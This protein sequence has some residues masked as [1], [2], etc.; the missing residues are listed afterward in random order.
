MTRPVL[1]VPGYQGSGPTHWQSL[2]ESALPEAR[3]VVMPDWEH[4]EPEG[5]IAALDAAVAACTEP[6]L[7][8]GHSLGCIAIVH[9]ALGHPR[10]IHGALLVAPA[11]VERPGGLEA[12]RP[13]GPIPQDRLPF[14][15]ILAASANDGFMTH[16]RAV[17]LAEAWGAR[18]VDLGAVGHLNVASGHGL[19][20]QGEALLAELR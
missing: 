16:A 6:P 15:A 7:L 20:K 19:W 17:A 4:P 18:R 1:I 10:P 13:F 8:V 11:D 3:R 12:L 5:W 2:W 14:P 9:W